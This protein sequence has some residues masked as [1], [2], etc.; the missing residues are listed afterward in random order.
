MSKAF[1][2][3]ETPDT[4]LLARAPPRLAPGEVRYVTP[5]GH[6]ALRG[7]V[8]TLRQ[9]REALAALPEAE[10]GARLADLEARLALLEATLAALTVLGPEATDEG[11]VGFA[12]WVTVEDEAGT[13]S[14]WRIVG[15]DEADSRQ[16]LVSVHSPVA[17]A[18]LRKHVGE[19]VEVERPG[20]RT[21]LTVLE[22][23][24]TPEPDQTGEPNLSDK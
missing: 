24:R 18:L 21:E 10:Q 23:R 12:T 8:A 13:R 7:E 20:G 19:S 17:R 6:A 4:P 1:T 22:V 16:R 15:P 11:V 5:E 14:T 9:S 3:E 2:S